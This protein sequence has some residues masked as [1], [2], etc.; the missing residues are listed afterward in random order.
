MTVLSRSIIHQLVLKSE[1]R[2][3]IQAKVEEEAAQHAVI[4]KL[5]MKGPWGKL[6]IQ[7][8]VLQYQQN[9]A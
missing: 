1:Q 2:P 5:M 8:T 7:Y 9:C 3:V 6:C 4:C